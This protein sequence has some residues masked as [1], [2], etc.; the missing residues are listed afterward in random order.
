MTKLEKQY[1]KEEKE[2]AEESN[3]SVHLTK[4]IEFTFF[5]TPLATPNG[6]RLLVFKI[7]L[8]EISKVTRFYRKIPSSV[9]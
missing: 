9:L 3:E 5:L 2:E 1:E 7:S 4:M 8:W 6:A